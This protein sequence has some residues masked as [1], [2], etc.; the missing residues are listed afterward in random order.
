MVSPTPATAEST[1]RLGRRDTSRRTPRL[2]TARMGGVACDSEARDP[3]DGVSAGPTGYIETHIATGDRPHGR[4]R[5]R[6]GGP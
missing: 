6:L 3:K 5:V 1:C 4:R 2:G